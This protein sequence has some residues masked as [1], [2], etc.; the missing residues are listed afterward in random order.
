MIGRKLSRVGMLLVAAGGSYLAMSDSGV[1][2]GQWISDW[3]Q[4]V[5]PSGSP[6]AVQPADPAPI[7]GVV[8]DNGPASI[9]ASDGL[10]PI[11]DLREALNFN[12]TPAWVVQRWPRVTNSVAP[13]GLHV[14]RVSLVTGTSV[15]DVCGCLTYYFDTRQRLERITLH[16]SAGDPSRLIAIVT[17]DHGLQPHRTLDAALYLKRWNGTPR[18]VLWIGHAP[19]ARADQPHLRYQIML[20]LNRTDGKYRLSDETAAFLD[21]RRKAGLW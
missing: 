5:R 17:R 8:G 6:L 9:A 20:E 3:T 11:V 19:L 15:D 16:G 13:D 18:C 14:M 2:V 1:P 21:E 12:I 4:A 7:G 10:E